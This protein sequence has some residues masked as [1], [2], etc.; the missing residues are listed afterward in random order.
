M[1]PG[2]GENPVIAMAMYWFMAA[3]SGIVLAAAALAIA[4][5]AYWLAVVV[6]SRIMPVVDEDGYPQEG[7]AAVRHVHYRWK[8]RL[9]HV[10]FFPY[11]PDYSWL[12]TLR[13]HFIVMALIGFGEVF[14][15]LLNEGERPLHLSLLTF[16]LPSLLMHAGGTFA[17]MTTARTGLAKRRGS[18][19]NTRHRFFSDEEIEERLASEHRQRAATRRFWEL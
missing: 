4:T 14:G 5:G 13:F 1:S 16:F 12:R 17:N 15:I 7:P 18:G 2:L 9:G 8:V 11:R 3:A 10:S 19:P 6:T